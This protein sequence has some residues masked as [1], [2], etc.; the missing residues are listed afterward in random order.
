MIR[1]QEMNIDRSIFSEI[2][3]RKL[4]TANAEILR[5]SSCLSDAVQSNEKTMKMS[6][7]KIARLETNIKVLEGQHET[8]VTEKFRAT[9][10]LAEAKKQ[11]EK[12]QNE[13]DNVHRINKKQEVKINVLKGEIEAFNKQKKEVVDKFNFLKR[14]E[15]AH[16]L[17]VKALRQD[18]EE[19]INQFLNGNGLSR[20]STNVEVSK[21]TSVHR[22]EKLES[23]PVGA[24]PVASSTNNAGIAVASTNNVTEQ[25]RSKAEPQIAKAGKMKNS[26]SNQIV[27]CIVF[28]SSGPSSQDSAVKDIP[29]CSRGRPRVSA[30]YPLLILFMNFVNFMD[31]RSFFPT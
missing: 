10:Q 4:K 14:R 6:S 9:K 23:S 21:V 8:A 31:L 26:F 7:D 12:I 3:L 22:V 29:S 11:C 27:H 20:Q 13:L 5:L 16:D 19:T 18:F 24:G 1:K 30:S 28:V 15:Y 25:V 17:A 2:L